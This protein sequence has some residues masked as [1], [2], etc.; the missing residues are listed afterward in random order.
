MPHEIGQGLATQA[1]Q[2]TAG[3]GSPEPL[4]PE[5][6][7]FSILELGDS[8][9]AIAFSRALRARGVC[10]VTPPRNPAIIE[11]PTPIGELE[12]VS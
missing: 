12:P 4:P 9:D 5:T 7:T 1:L 11:L 6:E 8:D 3:R 2:A 10:D